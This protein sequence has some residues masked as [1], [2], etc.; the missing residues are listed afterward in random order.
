MPSFRFLRVLVELTELWFIFCRRFI[1]GKEEI[2]TH[3]VAAEQISTRP[4]ERT[5]AVETEES[6]ASA[7]GPSSRR[8]TLIDYTR[9]LLES[10]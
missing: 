10:M 7:G 1:I 3:S 9:E 2:P 8:K 6:Q 5:A 4:H